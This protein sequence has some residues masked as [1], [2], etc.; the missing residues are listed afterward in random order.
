MLILLDENIRLNGILTGTVNGISLDQLNVP[1]YVENTVGRISTG[2]REMNRELVYD[3]QTAAVAI[4]NALSWLFASRINNVP[5]GFT[6]TGGFFN[7]TAQLN[8][9]QSGHGITLKEQYLGNDIFN[10]INFKA[11]IEGTLPHIANDSQI[12]IDPYVVEF[13]REQPGIIKS[14]VSMNFTLGPINATKIPL[15]LYQ[16]ITF[17][18]CQHQPSQAN[19][20][21]YLK[22]GGSMI[23]YQQEFQVVRYYSDATISEN[24]G[25]F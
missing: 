25:L 23:G 18:E 8:F 22:I 2:M 6:L 13:V 19:V 17:D 11:N 10:S 1:G 5:N 12:E 4:N 24:Q 3:I 9:P 7:R 14:S 15:V 21:H 20:P 16:T